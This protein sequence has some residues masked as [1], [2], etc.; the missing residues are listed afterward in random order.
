MWAFPSDL[1]LAKLLDLGT[2]K[3]MV[4][5]S[6]LVTRYIESNFTELSS[7]LIRGEGSVIE[8]LLTGPGVG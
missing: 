6:G 5:L 4:D 8:R 3:M 7:F 1:Q 2:A